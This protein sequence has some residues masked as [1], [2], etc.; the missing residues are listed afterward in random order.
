MN[1]R[2]PDELGGLQLISQT[3]PL[4]RVDSKTMDGQSAM[5]LAYGDTWLERAE[6]QAAWIRVDINGET[7]L[8]KVVG[9]GMLVATASG[10]SAYARAMGSMPVPI[11]S[12]VLTLAGSNIF[13]P[14]FWRPMNLPINSQITLTNVDAVN[15]RPLRAFVDGN[16]L[17][18]VREISIR[19]SLTAG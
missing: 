6:G 14:R 16:P 10:S 12:P 3:L 2:L 1:E 17:G 5:N 15:K 9:D 19:A 13:Q 18:L 11:D 8:D 4:L 7:M